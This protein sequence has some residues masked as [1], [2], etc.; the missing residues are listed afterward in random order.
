MD[1]AELART[2]RA[3]VEK[4][5]GILAADESTGT[6]KKRFDKIGVESSEANRRDY[7][8]LLFRSTD[9]MKCIS[10]VILYDETI[11]QNAADG[12]P[13]VKLIEAAGAIPG[14]KVDLGAKPLP[15]CPGETVTEGLDG[16][17]DRLIQYRGLGARFAKWRAVIDIGK[18]IPS[19]TSISTNA[20]ALARY[21][22]LCQEENLVPIVEPEVLMD[23][24]HTIDACAAVTEWTLKEV[25]YALFNQRVDLE[26]MVL[27]P[28]MILSGTKCPEQAGVDEVAARTIKCLKGC[29]PP[30]VP[31]VAFLSGGQSDED[32]TAHLNAM[33]KGF[34]VPWRLT[35]SYG[36]ALQAAPQKAWGGKSA[37]VPQAQQAFTHRARMNS[38]A[39]L[40]EWN[41]DLERQAA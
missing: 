12:T 33:N 26:G 34:D 10:G 38:L 18:G 17:R 23:G 4:G 36:R 19:F 1:T 27:K 6:I 9:G 37:N 41:P 24:D 32:A 30:A 11:R 15:L 8:E 28:N 31:G 35:F 29:V 14:I 25:F 7:R 3:M 5:R 2:A 20:H 40:G 16:L 39:T 22:A 21:A 13:L